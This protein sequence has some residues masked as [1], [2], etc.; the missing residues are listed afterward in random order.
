MATTEESLARRAKALELHLAG[1][2]YEAIANVVGYASKAGSYKAVQEALAAQAPPG[3][4]DSPVDY[5]T[6]IARLDA[7]LTGLWGKARRGDVQ[8]IDRV[9]RI[10]E[11]RAHLIA[12][13]A[14]AKVPTKKVTPLDELSTRRR[15]TGRPDAASRPL[16]D[17]S[18]Q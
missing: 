11:R 3:D 4:D 13:A 1:A 10:G 17:E 16:T 18:T 12:L 9:L 15:A 5:D 2:T 6:E 7:M 14:L 8:A